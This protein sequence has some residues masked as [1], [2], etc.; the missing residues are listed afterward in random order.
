MRRSAPTLLAAGVATLALAGTAAAHHPSEP[1][2]PAA[3]QV[4]KD[5]KVFLET[6]AEGVQIYGC[7]A[8][9]WSLVAPRATL[10]DRHGKLVATHFAGPTWQAKDGSHVKAQRVAGAPVA[11]TID[12]LK[13]QATET[14]P[15]RFG[16]VSFIQRINTTGGVA[17]AASTC[18]A[19]TLGAQREIPYT[20]DY[21]FFKPKESR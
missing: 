6:H 1:S 8:A 3:I 15:G 9:G 12:W 2:L 10:Y 4:D 13:L 11:G 14:T 5:H 18:S 17:P 16:R 19:D 21:R 20:A 7:T